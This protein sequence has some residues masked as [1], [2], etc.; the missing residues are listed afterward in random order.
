MAKKKTGTLNEVNEHLATYGE[1]RIVFFNSFE[2]MEAA[3]AKEMAGFTPIERLQHITE[4][5]M[6]A[7]HEE[8]KHKENDLTIYYK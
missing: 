2:E 5:I 3:D 1:K 4:F 8:L 7:Y 6:N